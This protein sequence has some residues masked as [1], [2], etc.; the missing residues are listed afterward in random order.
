MNEIRGKTKEVF[1]MKRKDSFYLWLRENKH[2][3]L[4]L[5]FIVYLALY[6]A[7]EVLTTPKYWVHSPIDDMIPF[8][9]IFVIPY[10]GWFLLFPGS[11]VYF[12]WKQQ[13]EEYLRL[14]CLMFMGATFIFITYFVF[15]TGLQ[16][17]PEITRN[18]ILCKLMQL[19]WAVDTPTNVCPSLHVSITTSIMVVMAKSE[20]MKNHKRLMY[21][22]DAA[23][24]LIIMATVFVKQHS[25]IDVF[26]GA[27]ITVI[28]YF[29]V[30]YGPVDKCIRKS[31][32][33]D[34]KK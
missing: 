9:E 33:S 28:F 34:Q 15:P 7:V 13:K 1:K 12:L 8:C 24:I 20:Y 2:A 5:Y 14:W 16:L 10:Y 6:F 23:G 31:I 11:L 30:Y 26:W 29:V 17:R 22:V 18:N 19:T 27:V 3:Y 32:S 21:L 25:V 4:M